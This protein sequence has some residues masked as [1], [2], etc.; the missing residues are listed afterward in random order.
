MHREVV[1]GVDWVGYIDWTVRDFHGYR[2]EAG[3]TYNAYLQC[4][5]YLPIAKSFY[6]S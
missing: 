2:T 5:C 1:P 3:S 6:I 4:V